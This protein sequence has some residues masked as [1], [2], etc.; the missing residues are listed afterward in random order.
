MTADHQLALWIAH[1]VLEL[2]VVGAMWRRKLYRA[3]PI[4]FTYVGFQI[5]IFAVL[6]PLSRYGPYAVYFYLFWACS[7]VN[8]VLG[9][10]IIHEIFLDVFRNYHT[11]RDLGSVMFKWAALVMLLV[12]FVVA[13]SNS[14]H[15][16]EPIMEAI[17]TVQ[18][19]VRV[20]QCGLVLFLIVFSRYLGVSWRQQSFG[21]AL[22]V[23]GFATAELGTLA[24][25]AGGPMSQ[26][27]VTAINLVAYNLA[28][29]VWFAYALLESPARAS[30]TILF[31][32]HRWE[33]SLGDL[34]RPAQ[35]DSLIPMFESMVDRALSR[36]QG[37]YS[38][39]ET[40]REP[41]AKVAASAGGLRT[42]LPRAR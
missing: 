15:D 37:D 4:F 40:A 20:A 35:D 23:G 14:G 27:S 32:P 13:A 10:M 11:L 28:I 22:G 36:T 41:A 21:I 5:L 34:H 1:P 7:A 19:C 9:F 8:L 24:L 25:Y 12:A 16:Q 2:A 31:T 26:V 38:R 3:F 29:A 6:F 42:V 17:T 39:K 18:R 30:E 33:R